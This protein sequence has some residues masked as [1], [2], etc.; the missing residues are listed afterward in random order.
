MRIGVEHD[1]VHELRPADEVRYAEALF[2][3]I[4]ALF[5]CRGCQSGVELL[6]IY[7][8]GCQDDG[9]RAAIFFIVEARKIGEHCRRLH[10]VGRVDEVLGDKPQRA[11]ERAIVIRAAERTAERGD[12]GVHMPGDPALFHED[13]CELHGHIPAL[14]RRFFL[15]AGIFHISR[16]SSALMAPKRV[17]R[18]HLN[19]NEPSEL[20]IFHAVM[21]PCSDHICFAPVVHNATRFAIRYAF[22]CRYALHMSRGCDG[23]AG[24]AQRIVPLRGSGSPQSCREVTVCSR[25][26]HPV[27]TI[28]RKQCT[29]NGTRTAA[30][31]RLGLV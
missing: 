26:G 18:G 19:Y 21:S 30:N 23:A 2:R 3:E 16:V 5:L 14:I 22:G 9:V 24:M 15:I 28:Y 7:R 17:D 8:A 13:G 11:R 31:L 12:E 1:G 6:L 10:D 27:P 4:D 29:E 25:C 20:K